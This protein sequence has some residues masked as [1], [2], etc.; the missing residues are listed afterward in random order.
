MSA[1][2]EL[3]V[4]EGLGLSSCA[5]HFPATDNATPPTSRAGLRPS[6]RQGGASDAQRG[7]RRRADP[8]V[9]SRRGERAWRGGYIGKDIEPDA[10]L[11]LQRIGA[12]YY[13]PGLGRW[14]SADPFIGQNPER[15]MEKLLESNLLSYGM[16]NPISGRDPSG[17]ETQRPYTDAH[18]VGMGEQAQKQAS[19]ARRDGKGGASQYSGDTLEYHTRLSEKFGIPEV[20]FKLDKKGRAIVTEEHIQLAMK[21]AYAEYLKDADRDADWDEVK[22]TMGVLDTFFYDISQDDSGGKHQG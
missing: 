8:K 13:A 16:G 12:R 17:A 4:E 22:E 18:V 5:F 6:R 3:R 11:G 10:D 9:E 20:V 21:V 7:A 15:M 14:V 19:E 2:E 1:A